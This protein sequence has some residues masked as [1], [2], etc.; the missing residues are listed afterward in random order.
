M[1][2]SAEKSPLDPAYGERALKNLSGAKLNTAFI[3][4]RDIQKRQVKRLEQARILP[5]E[6]NREIA[7]KGDMEPPDRRR[8]KRA[9]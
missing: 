4:G 2:E 1:Y 9:A 5:I 8:Q 6:L 3:G 7:S